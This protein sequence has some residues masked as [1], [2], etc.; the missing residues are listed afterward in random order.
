MLREK[1]AQ[2]SGPVALPE[3]IEVGARNQTAASFAGSLRARGEDEAGIFAGLQALAALKF[4]GYVGSTAAS[5]P[6]EIDDAELRRIAHD[7]SLKPPYYN[8]PE[9]PQARAAGSDSAYAQ[10]DS[11]NAELFAA[12]H[13]DHVRYDHA[14]GR[15]LVF[16]EHYWTSD[17]DGAL[18]R[19]AKA[20]ARRR[21]SDALKID[22]PDQKSRAMKWAIQSESK[23]RLDAML[24]LAKSEYPVADAGFGWDD[25][26][27]LL[28]VANGVVDLRT[29]EL[30][31]GLP[32]D[33]ITMSTSVAFGPDARCERWL[34]FVDEVFNGDPAMVAF[35]KRALGYSLTGST[36][37]QV[38]FLLYGFGA[39]G[40]SVLLNVL[41]RLLGDYSHNLPFSAF[42][43]QER[44]SGGFDIAGLAGRR[45]A[46]SAETNEGTRL[47]EARVKA[48]TGG[49]AISAAFKYKDYSSFK[50]VAK[51]WLAV[52]HLPVIDD[53][54]EGMWRR[55]R[56]VPFRQEF[57]GPDRDP[58]L[59]QKLLAELPGILRWAIDGCLEYQKGGLGA[60]D[61]VMLA[62]LAYRQDSD[63][64]ASFIS[65]CCDLGAGLMSRPTEMAD[66]YQEWAKKH[67]LEQA[68]K[69][70]RRQF[71]DRMRRRFD[72]PREPGTGQRLYHG[73]AIRP[74]DTVTQRGGVYVNLSHE[75]SLEKVPGNGPSSVTVSQNLATPCPNG[76]GRM[77]I[78]GSHA[79][80][81]TVTAQ[82][83]REENDDGQ[84]ARLSRLA[85]RTTAPG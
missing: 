67:Q 10:T 50:P 22:D 60:P 17:T 56:I 52:N 19:M 26:P 2:A 42:E 55:I 78:D 5:G 84:P 70:G 79:F 64:L 85:A 18:H 46:T 39:N 51:F 54:S 14:R 25:D 29:G 40:K 20:V 74:C 69:L 36:S 57:R 65:A 27:W 35:V 48:L 12:M 73:I 21:Q 71:A 11:G 9:R 13:R 58:D 59:E 4:E 63:P 80:A 43:K 3:R 41:M 24:A 83:S 76:C 23:N 7:Y 45:V 31:D 16:R 81:A 28:G 66:A 38:L 30:R 68:D 32:E 33:R 37:E 77:G 61:E 6:E 62:T 47:N 75:P 44:S 82:T 8:G 34:K 15:W 1:A 53:D 49:D 72:G